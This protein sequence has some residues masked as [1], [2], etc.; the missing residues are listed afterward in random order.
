MSTQELYNQWSSTYDTV[1]NKTR[2]L[3]KIAGQQMLSTLSFDSVLEL[4]CGTGKNTAWL[5]ERAKQV[6]AVDLSEGMLSKA[7]EKM[8]RDGVE[9]RQADI[10]KRWDFVPQKVDLITCS[11]IL[12]HIEDLHFILREAAT[13][14][15][16]GG[17]FYICELHPYKQYAGSKARFETEKGLQVLECFTHHVSD[18]VDAAIK[19]NFAVAGLQEWF[20]EEDR[21]VPPR[22]ISFLFRNVSPPNP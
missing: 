15:H 14:L 9:F 20:D 3:E 19:N 7:K 11:L 4:G 17:Y 5:S 16:D 10:T 21:N 2:D 18:Y 13:V 22:L 8:Q 6:L 1:E 12:E